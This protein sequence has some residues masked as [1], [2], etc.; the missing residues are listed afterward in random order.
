MFAVLVGRAAR[1]TMSAEQRQQTLLGAIDL[2][3]GAALV[4]RLERLGEVEGKV[5]R[6]QR[7]EREREEAKP[8]AQI[9]PRHCLVRIRAPRR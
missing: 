1:F 7:V 6:H 3:V 2:D 9:L 4:R 5:H 8:W